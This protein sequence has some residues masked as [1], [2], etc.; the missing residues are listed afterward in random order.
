MKSST[1][2]AI[3]FLFAFATDS[4]AQSET[5]KKQLLPHEK[6]EHKISLEAKEAILQ[7]VASAK[8]YENRVR[9]SKK[10]FAPVKREA[11]DLKKIQS[12]PAKLD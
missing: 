11:T 9:V 3:A 1:I 5:R 2:I 7:R 10:Q 8:V 12:I 4:S 6:M